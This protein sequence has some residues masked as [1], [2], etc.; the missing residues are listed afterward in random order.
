MTE[1]LREM[2]TQTRPEQWPYQYILIYNFKGSHLYQKNSSQLIAGGRI[3]L[4]EDEPR[5]WLSNT[6]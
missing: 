1:S 5:C 3:R 6:K 4:P 2:V